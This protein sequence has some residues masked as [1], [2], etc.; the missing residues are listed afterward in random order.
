MPYLDF[1]ITP[2]RAYRAKVLLG[3]MMAPEEDG[4]GGGSNR[5]LLFTWWNYFTL[6]E[7]LL[8]SKDKLT[9]HLLLE[10]LNPGDYYSDGQNNSVFARWEF[11]YTF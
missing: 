4:S 6:G 10:Y 8:S 5:G 9:G 3:Y 11:L 2:S 7:K 1:E